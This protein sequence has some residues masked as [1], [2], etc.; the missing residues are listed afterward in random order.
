MVRIRGINKL[1]RERGRQT[2]MEHEWDADGGGG[3]GMEDQAAG[4]GNRRALLSLTLPLLHPAHVSL[5][6]EKL[7]SSLK[8]LPS[9][10]P[11]FYSY[12]RDQVPYMM[13]GGAV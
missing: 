2:R 12:M 10:V 1:K 4:M 5:V 11:T 8:H 9:S 3:E 6:P 13:R 7:S